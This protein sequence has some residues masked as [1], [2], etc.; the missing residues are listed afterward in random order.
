MP[1]A[2][3]EVRIADAGATVVSGNV[4]VTLTQVD[5]LAETPIVSGPSV[6]VLKGTT[7]SQ[8]FKLRCKSDQVLR[9]SNGRLTELGRLTEIRRSLDGG[10]FATLATG[11]LSHVSEVGRGLF[12]VEVSDERWVERR[13]EI[14][15]TTDTMQLHPP[16]FAS[17]WFDQ[18]AAGDATYIVKEIDGDAVRIGPN[19][20]KGT[21]D[22]R[23][24]PAGLREALATDLVAPDEQANTATNS[25]GNFTDLRFEFSGGDRTVIGF[26]ENLGTAGR[27][28]TFAG[29]LDEFAP[30]ASGLIR[31]AWVY[32]SG[33]SFSVDDEIVGRFYWP[34]GVALNDKVPLHIGGA[35]GIHPMEL[36]EDILDGDYGAQAVRYSASAMTT[37]QALPFKPVW[38]RIG[39]SAERSEW[40]RDN[41]YRPYNIAPL[42]G[43]D[44]TP[45][46]TAIRLPQSLDP[47]TLEI[48]TASDAG[49]PS[50]SHGSREMV[51]VLEFHCRAARRISRVAR[52]T[53][54]RPADLYELVRVRVPDIEHDT[55]A[56]LGENRHKVDTELILDRPAR[57]T[58]EIGRIAAAL[59]V[60]LFDV[61]GDGPQRGRVLV[62]E[63]STVEVGD[64]VLLD[65]D[66]LAGFNVET[67]DRSGDRLV[68]LLS[69]LERNPAAREF[70]Y[71]D[72]GP[73]ASPLAAPTV[74]IAQDV[75]DPDLVNVTVSGVPAGAQATVECTAGTIGPTEY[76]LVRSGVGNETIA[77]RLNAPS[78]NAYCRAHSTAPGRIRSPFATDSV[79]LSTRAQ[80]TDASITKE[81]RQG[82]VVW[83][84]PAGT[85]GMR[86]DWA[87]HRR[88]E[89]PVFGSNEE[90][91]DSSDGGFTIASV[92]AREAV[93]ALLT[94]YPGFSGGS[95]TGTAG[96]P[97][98]V[99][100]LLARPTLPVEV[101]D[102]SVLEVA[103]KWNQDGGL[104]VNADLQGGR[105]LRAAFSATAFPSEATV[106]A[107]TAESTDSDGW[108]AITASD[109][110]AADDQV[111]VSMKAYE[112]EDVG[113]GD[114]SPVLR[115]RVDTRTLGPIHK[116]ATARSVT[117][118]TVTTTLETIT[119]PA[120][121][122]G[123][124]GTI[125]LIMLGR[126][127][128][129]NDLKTL[130]V[131]W[132]GTVVTNLIWQPLSSYTGL[133]WSEILISNIA[134][135][136]SQRIIARRYDQT[137]PVILVDTT[138]SE[139]T[140]ADVDIEIDGRLDNGSDRITL[141]F[142]SV[143][144][145]GRS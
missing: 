50:W 36:L 76:E 21:P 7:V 98:V 86:T 69:F 89:D 38:A 4:D 105:Y 49:L 136:S 90:D 28:I 124:D 84:V 67:G 142:T 129:T 75:G 87:T 97:L 126:F 48:L 128:G 22:V 60:E 70:E 107:E 117:G 56:T 37:L 115:V 15:R 63:N 108:A 29:L 130:R 103:P 33:H 44:L 68:M 140:T 127:V 10:A 99:T 47:G 132:D 31:N 100:A 53:D 78:G 5:D 134:S 58:G 46:P 120:N 1:T 55:V 144:Y 19:D 59:A 121:S 24:V 3:Y 102:V 85:G 116:D 13:S 83:T 143:E 109:L 16:G 133:V 145:L 54:E 96:A 141:E 73:N 118:T 88:D 30:E 17:V 57:W 93:S 95:V 94:P 65:Q 42:V 20:E 71:L 43:T 123:E 62:P 137:N 41:V 113:T 104:T 61:F 66:T 110:F 77:F 79:A 72:L 45:R 11:R 14:F 139:D 9:N 52:L 32:F 114:E 23:Q 26:R 112:Y 135:A 111:Y 6:D 81:G 101:L 92:V 27:G 80:I 18:P 91:F 74:S 51:T 12:D 122:L 125:R 35:D 34:N 106:D 82:V 2:V 8:P 131:L 119:I 25:A 138:A 64:P 40:L 39:A